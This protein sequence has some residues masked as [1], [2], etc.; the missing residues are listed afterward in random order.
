MEL[1]RKILREYDE[2]RDEV[3][4][5][6]KEMFSEEVYQ[7]IFRIF[8]RYVE[9]NHNRLFD[10]LKNLSLYDEDIR[11]EDL[12]SNIIYKY[13]TEHKD[14]PNSYIKISFFP[15]EM[16]SFFCD[17]RDYGI[18]DMVRK[19][20]SFDYDYGA[21]Y[22][23]YDFDDYYFD[24]I[25]KQNLD[26]LREY[27]LRDLEGDPSEEGFKEFVEEEFGGE[28]GCAAG[29][30]QHSADIDLLHSDF[31]NGVIDYLSN[32]GGKLQQQVD[33]EGHLGH[34]LEY[35]G[36][37]E[38]GDIASSERFKS[39]LNAELTHG[40]PTF[41][42]ILDGILEDERTGWEQEYNSFLPEDCISINTDKHFRYGGA[43]DVDWGF[44]N[45]IL[46]DRI[47]NY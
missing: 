5:F 24:K 20:F 37:V 35:V 43:G 46:L 23:C 25:D 39:Q 40:Y 30:A 3:S 12:E 29:D 36:H 28:I 11:S 1:I 18:R 26:L 38:L 41:L 4:I 42:E 15:S 47:N 14:R 16:S 6:N 10:V 2:E 22:D 45:E 33:N 9:S 32:F 17:D 7:K 27:Y 44:F 19:Y 31:E 34:A 21:H 13:L 8:D